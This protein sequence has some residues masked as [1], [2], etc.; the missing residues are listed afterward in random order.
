MTGVCSIPGCGKAHAARGWCNKHYL[1]W[2]VYGSPTA[3]Q[4]PKGN[5]QTEIAQALLHSTPDQCWLWPFNK[6]KKGYGQIKWKGRMAY[7]HRVVCAERHG[8]PPTTKHQAAHLCGK[9]SCINPHHLAWKTAKENESDKDG[10]GTRHI[11]ERNPMA[12]LTE[13]DVLEI[14]RLRE[15]GETQAAAGELFG[16]KQPTVSNIESGR[17]WGWLTKQEDEQNGR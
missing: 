14:I 1:R 12:K 15:C 17:N 4:T 6:M 11:G 2:R 13:A 5:A 8:A 9:S 7:A 10:H 16:V 3:G